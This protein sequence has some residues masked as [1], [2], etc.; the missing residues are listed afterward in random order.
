MSTADAIARATRASFCMMTCSLVAIEIR[1]WTPPAFAIALTTSCA[2]S[3]RQ[4]LLLGKKK[5][6]RQPNKSCSRTPRN[7]LSCGCV[8]WGLPAD[9]WLLLWLLHGPWLHTTPWSEPTAPCLYPAP[10][11][12][13]LKDIN[14]VLCQYSWWKMQRTKKNCF[15][16]LKC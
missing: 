12:P 1:C 4:K 6:K 16:S 11:L 2:V 7:S 8:W 14:T 10:G 5:K 13:P 15:N 3:E 9:D